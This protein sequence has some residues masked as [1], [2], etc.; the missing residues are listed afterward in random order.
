[1]HERRVCD[2]C[3]EPIEP[4]MWAYVDERLSWHR[5]CRAPILLDDEP[6]EV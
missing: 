4:R 1:M 6:D 5:S 2:S 3:G